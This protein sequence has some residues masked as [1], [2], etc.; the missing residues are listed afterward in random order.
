MGARGR[1]LNLIYRYSKLVDDGDFEG[2]GELFR[3][4]EYVIPSLNLSLP[5]REIRS[6]LF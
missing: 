3:D 4:G 2:V 1:I 6:L 5:G